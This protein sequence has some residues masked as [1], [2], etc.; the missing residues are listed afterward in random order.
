MKDEHFDIQLMNKWRHSP[1]LGT[2]V[3]AHQIFRCHQ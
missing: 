3:I 2:V 1:V